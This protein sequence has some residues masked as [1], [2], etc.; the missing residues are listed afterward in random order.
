MRNLSQIRLRNVSVCRQQHS[1]AKSK[2]EADKWKLGTQCLQKLFER[3]EQ[4]ASVAIVQV[5]TGPRIRLRLQLLTQRLNDFVQRQGEHEWPQR[6]SLV[7]PAF[8]RQTFVFRKKHTEPRQRP[9]R[10]G[11]KL[12]CV[13]LH[14]TNDAGT[15]HRIKSV[16]DVESGAPSS[17]QVAIV[18]GPPRS[19]LGMVE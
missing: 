3:L 13:L 18:T 16:T 19:P 8:V 7:N 1:F 12:W 11:V 4:S 2:G 9:S 6:A 14:L 17:V 15:T 5:E 10:P